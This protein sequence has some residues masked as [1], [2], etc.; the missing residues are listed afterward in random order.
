MFGSRGKQRTL[1]AER[2]RVLWATAN[3]YLYKNFSPHCFRET[4]LDQPQLRF[5]TVFHSSFLVLFYCR[6]KLDVLTGGSGQPS[7]AVLRSK[8]K[9]PGCV[10]GLTWSH[11]DQR[12]AA[13]YRDNSPHRDCSQLQDSPCELVEI[14]NIRTRDW[15][16][17]VQIPN[18][19]VLHPLRLQCQ[20][21]LCFYGDWF[22]RVKLLL[23]VLI[24]SLP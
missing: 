5:Q 10:S 12:S 3:I 23:Q 21:H 14:L 9:L 6:Q 18:H 20:A 24:F 2:G 17:G 11:Q 8:K 7:L 19:L 1:H 16:S 13:D 15:Q 22:M 4:K